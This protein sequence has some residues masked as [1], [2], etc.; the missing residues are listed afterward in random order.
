M[1]LQ[2]EFDGSV[3]E[4]SAK[5]VVTEDDKKTFT[6][7]VEYSRITLPRDRCVFFS[8]ELPSL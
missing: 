5:A 2:Y 7:V 6:S 1:K 8:L 4:R 3:V